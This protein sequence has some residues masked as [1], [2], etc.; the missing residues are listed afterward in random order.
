MRK[1]EKERASEGQKLGEQMEAGEKAAGVLSAGA[2]G[3]GFLSDLQLYSHDGHRD[4]VQEIQHLYQHRGK[5]L[6]GDGCISAAFWAG[7]LSAGAAEYH[8]HQ[9]V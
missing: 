2:A 1:G 3:T 7:G 5:S 9:P 4:R 8:H 6:G